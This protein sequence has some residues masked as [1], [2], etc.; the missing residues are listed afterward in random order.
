MDILLAEAGLYH[1]PL[2]GFGGA[3]LNELRQNEP[4]RLVEF[5]SGLSFILLFF[6]VRNR[7]IKAQALAKKAKKKSP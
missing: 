3:F 5:G 6:I 7:I 4:S 2:I 1:V